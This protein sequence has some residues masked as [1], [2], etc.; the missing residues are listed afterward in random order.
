MNHDIIT[1][2]EVQNNG[3]TIH[4]YYNACAG[5]W[6]AYGISAYALEKICSENGITA[7]TSYSHEMQ[8]P[9]TMVI[10]VMDV[11]KNA[12]VAKSSDSYYVLI[13]DRRVADE[14]YIVWAS[15]LRRR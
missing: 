2:N 8:M 1:L 7:L 4:L 15:R 11:A 3:M 14:V 12:N 5:I 9:C 6:T 10:D 13:T